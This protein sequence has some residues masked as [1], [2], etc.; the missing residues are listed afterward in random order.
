MSK[1]LLI[2]IP[3]DNFLDQEIDALLEALDEKNIMYDIASSH[4]SAAKGRFGKIIV[5]DIV[6][7]AGINNNYDGY[8][9]VGEEASREYL[10]NFE[11][12]KLLEFIKNRSK[13]IGT[14]GYSATILTNTDLLVGKKI[15][16]PVDIKPQL[17][18][19]GAYF[20]NHSLEV[21]S[22]IITA[23]GSFWIKDF[24][25]VFAS[26]LNDDTAKKGRKYLR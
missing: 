23:S 26:H 2:I 12:I 5:P 4:I 20:S 11:I 8:I 13:L 24:V 22:N 25:D 21:D 7:G 1:K 15:A 10:N 19:A 9:F 3:H 18:T 14:I 6:I 16:A 17:E